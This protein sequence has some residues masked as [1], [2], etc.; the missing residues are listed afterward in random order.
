MP[1]EML[2]EAVLAALPDDEAW[3]KLK[4]LPVRGEFD[5]RRVLGSRYFFC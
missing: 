5:V 3:R 4:L 1:L 2:R